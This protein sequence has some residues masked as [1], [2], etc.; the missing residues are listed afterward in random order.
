MPDQSHARLVE[1][2]RVDARAAWDYLRTKYPSER[3]YA[4]GFHTTDIASYF[5]P[6]ACGEEGLAKVAADY[7][8][9][10]DESRLERKRADLRWSIP[11][12]PYG[13]EMDGIAT[14]IEA[15][16]ARRPDPDTLDEIPLA[17]E[18]R[19]RTNAAVAA[20]KSLDSEGLFGVLEAR[21]KITIF[22]E[23]DGD[24]VREWAKKLNPPGV[25]AAFEKIGAIEPIGT[26]T[27]FGTKKV[28][29]TKHLAVSADRRLVA[30]ATDYW[31]CLFD[32]VAMK[33]LFC[34]RIPNGKDYSDIID[35]AISDDGKTI[36]VA[37][38]DW[39]SILRGQDWKEQLDVRLD[40]RPWVL[41]MAPDASWFAIAGHDTKITIFDSNGGHT[42]SLEA[43]I[44]YVRKID[45]S[46]DGSLLAA[47]DAQAGVQIWNTRDWSLHRHLKVS[48]DEVRFDPSGRFVITTWPAGTGISGQRLRLV[49]G[50]PSKRTQVL[51]IWEIDSG[52][53]VRELTLPG[54][55][56][57]SAAFSPDGKMIVASI[58]PM[59]MIPNEDAVLF[60]V[61]TGNVL[62]RL[63][64]DFRAITDFMFLPAR[65]AIA[66]AARGFTLR[67]L[68]LWEL[69]APT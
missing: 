64:G 65:N 52:E 37:A 28:D 42:R 56:F 50:S 43:H 45:V 47:I 21:S 59:K 44:S 54:Y 25:Y 49:H 38:N 8:P 40:S 68:T 18:I 34:R 11:D 9:R 15:E 67:P 7:A 29:E 57:Q 41:A 23:R 60:D 69:R 14:H 12:S 2:M 39:L 32:V 24:F 35:I 20:L 22:I 16:L 3:F 31:A 48:G 30:A 53:L 10:G 61:T 4:F 58:H 26:F 19:A 27:Q 6:F 63:R 46:A 33:Q 17:R 36:A 13:K 62:N 5:S 1:A 66:F 51:P 55:R